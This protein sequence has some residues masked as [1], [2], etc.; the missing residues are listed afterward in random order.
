VEGAK[1]KDPVSGRTYSSNISLDAIDEIEVITG[2]FNAE[3]GEAMSGVVNVR[4]KEGGDRF[5]GAFTAKTD[6]LGVDFPGSQNSNLYELNVSGPARVVPKLFYMFSAQSN[7]SDTYLPHANQ[8]YPR[9]STYDILAP[10]EENRWNALGKLTYKLDETKKLSYTHSRSIQINQGYFDSVMDKRVYYPYSFQENL[11]NYNTI[12]TEITQNTLNWKQTLS[13]KTFY[14]LTLSQMFNRQHS[15]VRNL[16]WSEYQPMLDLEP[17]ILYPPNI[18]GDIEVRFGDGFY[19]TGDYSNWHDHY[20]ENYIGEIEVT[21]QVNER[22]QLKSGFEIDYSEQQLLDIEDPWFNDASSLGLSYDMYKVYPTSG[23]LYVQDKIEYKGMIAN[24]G[25]RFDYWFPGEYVADALNNPSPGVLNDPTVAELQQATRDTYYRETFG[26]FGCRGKGHLSP[27]LGISHPVTDRDVLYFSYGHFSQ[28]PQS[29]SYIYSHLKSQSQATYQLFG[30]PNLNPEVTVSY[31]LGIKHKFTRDVVLDA[32]AFYKDIFNYITAQKV[33]DTDI[34]FSYSEHTMFFNNDHARSRGIEL[35]L[36]FRSAPYITGRA[37]LT[38]MIATG[39]SSSPYT[40]LYIDAGLIDQ[41]TLGEEYLSWDKPL[42]FSTYV[43]FDVPQNKAPRLFGVKTF[44]DW[45]G[46]VRFDFQSGK[47]Y[48]PIVYHENGTDYYDI[49]NNSAI[50]R[51]V[52]TVD[53]KL[54]KNFRPKK[55]MVQFFIEVENIFAFQVPRLINPLTGTAYE[56]GDP[57]PY[58]WYDDPYDLPPTNPSRYINPRQVWAGVTI[59]Y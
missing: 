46:K 25:L 7:L 12:T 5:A 2:G 56:P 43:M 40:Q 11:N 24:V 54:Y 28:K 3:Y 19:E 16:H 36:Q 39:K 17:I 48:T 1:V 52:N 33:R 58:S 18:Y 27:R 8:L 32:T 6:N 59:R 22:H 21:S 53:L 4:L 29:S 45:G 49:N 44:G 55:L 9:L 10:R 35:K 20:S 47:R 41:K 51:P 31:E 23:A 38:Y 34:R 15:A 50:S 30:N 37:D 26:L 42:L 57:L 14:E 13:R